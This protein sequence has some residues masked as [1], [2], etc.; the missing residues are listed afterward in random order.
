[1]IDLYSYVFR[2]L[3]TEESLDNAGRL[4]KRKQRS[5]EL[6]M[7]YVQLGLNDMDPNIV[8]VAETMAIV[9]TAIHAFENTVRGFIS[10]KMQEEK[11]TGWWE[12][13]SKKK[14]VQ[15][16]R[17]EGTL[18]NPLDGIQQEAKI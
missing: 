12:K 5:E 6:E 4:N 17:I 3:V 16:L 14:F 13:S 11:G 10:Q 1:M 9:Y 18:N 8:G 7:Q 15:E 2:A